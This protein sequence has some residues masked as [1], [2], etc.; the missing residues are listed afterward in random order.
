MGYWSIIIPEGATNLI[1]NPSVELATT[2]YNAMA[3][4]IAR[5]SESPAGGL[6]P[7]R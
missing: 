4:T 5:N 2:N 7:S 1:T 3:G 6:M